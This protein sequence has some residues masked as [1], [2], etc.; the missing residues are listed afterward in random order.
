MIIN[1]LNSESTLMHRIMFSRLKDN[2][3][4]CSHQREKLLLLLKAIIPFGTILCAKWR[5]T[6]SL[7]GN[8]KK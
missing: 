7:F 4:D 1:K 5:Y 3:E 8:I 6:A 2:M